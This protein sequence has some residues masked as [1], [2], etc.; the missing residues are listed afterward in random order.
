MHF[1]AGN[2]WDCHGAGTA[3]CQYADGTKQITV[4]K[5]KERDKRKAGQILKK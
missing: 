5:I 1:T 3:V 2:L 4:P